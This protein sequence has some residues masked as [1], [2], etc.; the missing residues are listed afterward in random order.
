MM[1]LIYTTTSPYARKIRMIILEKD[2]SERVELQA[3]DL[4]ADRALLN[5]VNPLGKVPVLITAQG[6]VIYDSPV[7]CEYIDSL[8]AISPVFPAMGA[9][10]WEALTDQALADGLLDAAVQIMVLRREMGDAAPEKLVLALDD[11]IHAALNQMDSRVP[12][13]REAFDIGQM[14][15]IAA[16]EYQMLRFPKLYWRTGRPSL[17][18]WYD[19]N[20]D[21]PS[22]FATRP[23]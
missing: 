20:A 9:A 5:S 2:L 11:K 19:E 1:K 15:Y 6:D 23:A 4:V 14:S 18:L 16:I 12:A 7:I 21:R 22:A 10:R 13:F 3:I 17:S 8:T